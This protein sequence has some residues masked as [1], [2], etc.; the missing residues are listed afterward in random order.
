M[1][2]PP[3]AALPSK[4]AQKQVTDELHALEGVS[5]SSHAVKQEAAADT[6]YLRAWAS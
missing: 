6:G 3:V 5:K 4:E 2:E 1:Y